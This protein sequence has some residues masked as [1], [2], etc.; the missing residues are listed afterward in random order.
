MAEKKYGDRVWEIQMNKRDGAG[1]K[2][3][4]GGSLMDE[5]SF[6]GMIEQIKLRLVNS[7]P[8]Y[9]ICLVIT[10]FESSQKRGFFKDMLDLFH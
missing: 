2:L 7:P 10:D 4:E 1:R 9:E 6:E 3:A 8:H 5:V